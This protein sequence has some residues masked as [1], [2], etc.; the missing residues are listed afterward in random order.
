MIESP[1]SYTTLTPIY[2]KLDNF[3][4]YEC[5]ELKNIYTISP[6][7]NLLGH[8]ANYEINKFF[9][10]KYELT[11]LKKIIKLASEFHF[12]VKVSKCKQK[13]FIIK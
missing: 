10:S 7:R 6:K 9:S 8:F 2:K 5:N 13:I 4:I 11:V 12:T 1:F 3:F